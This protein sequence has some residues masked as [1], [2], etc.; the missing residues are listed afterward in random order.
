MKTYKL[1][2][3]VCGTLSSKIE[4]P[5]V[6][7]NCG[8]QLEPVIQ[9]SKLDFKKIVEN[10]CNR[11]VW[12]YKELL[13]LDGIEEPVTLGEGATPLIK[14]DNIAKM[15]GMKAIY[16]KNE[17]LNPSGTY[18][19]RFSTVALSI[20]KAKNTTAVALGSAG[21]A[22]A[23]I[24]AYSAKANIPC[25][26]M[27]P[28]GAVAE[29]AWQVRGYGA[30][31]IKMEN[32]IHDCIQHAKMGEN[33]FGWKSLTTNMLTNPLAS[34]GYKTVSYEIGKQLA[35]K[36]PDWVIVP[37]GG[38]ALISK[39][40]KGFKDLKENGVTD[41]MPHIVAVQSE[42][43]APLVKAFHQQ[44]S[45]P[46]IWDGIPKTSAFAIADVCSYDGAAALDAIYKTNGY[47]ETVSE[48]E[49]LNAMNTLA[50]KEGI[51]AEPASSCTVACLIKMLEKGIIQKE[52]SVCC[53]I[54]GNGMRDLKL[55]NEGKKEVPYI[56]YKDDDSFISTVSS[57]LNG[58]EN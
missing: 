24:S 26:V 8:G 29:R 30:H 14:A 47:A 48:E 19:D 40:Y 33:L 27:L 16:A 31:L 25:F 21:N 23:S 2:C 28:P 42:H 22:A 55:F 18:K 15:L 51:V 3:S 20:E 56:K 57:I 9:V 10:G 43:C 53:I 58:V 1:V 11:G 6:C 12:D 35:W 4:A 5:F 7:E 46:E 38:A 39:I 17:T 34:D 13:P 41:K 45:V 49:I 32:T 52:D 36:V 54:T 50:S 37:V 44:A